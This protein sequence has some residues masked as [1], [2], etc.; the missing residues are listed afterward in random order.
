LS[1]FLHISPSNYSLL[2]ISQGIPDKVPVSYNKNCKETSGV[3]Q[4]LRNKF[5]NYNV[6]G[7][8]EGSGREKWDKGD[9][10][11]LDFVIKLRKI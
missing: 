11:A 6:A 8:G 10:K 4:E 7:V 5:L 2:G 9:S 3:T 1:F